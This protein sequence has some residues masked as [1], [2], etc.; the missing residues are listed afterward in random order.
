MLLRSSQP[1]VGLFSWRKQEDENLLQ[2]VI[3]ACQKDAGTEKSSSG[4]RTPLNETDSSTRGNLMEDSKREF[5][6][7]T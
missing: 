1:L 5:L 7:R 3:K 6:A 4:T 2:I